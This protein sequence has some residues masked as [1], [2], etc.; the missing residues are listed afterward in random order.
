M[1]LNWGKK[2][3]VV[4]NKS[5]F[6]YNNCGV[7]SNNDDGGNRGQRVDAARE[8][9][10]DLAANSFDNKPGSFLIKYIGLT[11]LVVFCVL[12]S[13]LLSDFAEVRIPFN[14]L[15][16]PVFIGEMLLLFCFGL[17]FV[18][19]FQGKVK[20]KRYHYVLALYGVFVLVKTFFGYTRWGI[21]A[22]RNAAMF[23]Y[24]L[25]AFLAFHF[26][27]ID[28][29]KKFLYSIGLL[30]MS[31]LF[32]RLSHGYYVYV[33]SIFALVIAW[34]LKSYKFK[35]PVILCLLAVL[36]YKQLFFTSRGVLLAELIGIGI[37]FIGLMYVGR[38]SWKYKITGLAIAC[39]LLF[40]GIY[41]LG[42]KIGISSL[43]TINI[44]MRQYNDY[45][46][47][48]AAK[49]KSYTVGFDYPVQVYVDNN[50]V[51]LE[52]D[53]RGKDVSTAEVRLEN[54]KRGKDV[55]TAEVRLENDKRGKDVSTAKVRLENDKRGIDP[56]EMFLQC[57]RNSAIW[58]LL[59]WHDMIEEVWVKK[60]WVGVDFGKPFLSSN[61]FALGWS[62]DG[63]DVG[64]LEPH[65][66][67]IHIVYR[68]GLVGII[69]IAALFIMIGNKIKYFFQQKNSVGI[70]LISLP[71]YWIVVSNFAVVLELPYLAIPCWVCFGVVMR[72]GVSTANKASV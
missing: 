23:Y 13:I 28:V 57:S 36:P 37:I 19:L 32:L 15:D 9:H 2:N 68:A 44:I 52:N 46:K 35:Y 11:L 66:S 6:V 34:V 8:Y 17:F 60:I 42:D 53:K 41:F 72:Y 67:F 27:A 4:R 69:M 39:I 70:L 12:Y 30:L 47:E 25:F 54:D 29:K 65:N 1:N 48:I 64:W 21:L 56:P 71:L 58:R 31:V 16:S 55:S 40:S 3:K 14:F 5:I 62:S 38:I 33:Y 10:I 24:P 59:V 26:S 22:F 49:L 43:Y 50:A 63:R 51:R 18:E 20:V 45:R 61:I 7:L